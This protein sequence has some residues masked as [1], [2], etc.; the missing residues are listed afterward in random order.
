MSGAGS[1]SRAA[2]WP[3][4]DQRRPQVA[5]DVD[6]QGL[7]RRD[8]EHPA[9]LLRRR[10][11]AARGQPVER[12]E[13]RGQ[14][15][16]RAGRRHDQGVVPGADRLPGALLGGRGRA[17]RPPE[18]RRGGGGE[19]LEHVT[20]HQGAQPATA[21]RHPIAPGHRRSNQP[22]RIPRTSPDA[23]PGQPGRIP[24]VP[25]PDAYPASPATPALRNNCARD[26]KSTPDVRNV[27]SFLIT[28]AG[29]DGGGPASTLA[30]GVSGG[31]SKGWRRRCWRRPR[32][33]ARWGGH[34]TEP[35]CHTRPPCG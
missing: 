34:H 13:E 20:S 5:L 27:G 25:A 11:A 35:L 12:P 33:A 19:P 8:V 14:R 17:E 31:T 24:A 21:H 1:P 28:C 23:Y 7:E 3:M 4:P 9:A 26:E 32:A 10:R 29:V 2:A 15:L 6:G 16:A 22:G 30:R 18:P